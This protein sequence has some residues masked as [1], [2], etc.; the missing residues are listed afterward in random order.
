MKGFV[1]IVG[2]G[3]GDPELL[4]VKAMRALEASDVVLHDDLVSP[5]ILSLVPARALVVNVGKRCGKKA[6][7]QEQIEDLMVTH[8]NAGRVVVRLKGGDPAI[9]GRLAG[10]IDALRRAGTPFQIIPGVTSALAAAA[11]AQI[12]LTDRRCA[13]SVVFVPGHRQ[14]GMPEWRNFV[15][16]GATLVIYM[17]GSSYG[18]LARD[19]RGSGL[20]AD[21]PCLI[22]SRAGAAQQLTVRTT[23]RKLA[24]TAPLP[25]PALL[26]VGEVAAR[27][28]AS[29]PRTERPDLDAHAVVDVFADGAEAGSFGQ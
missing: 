22:V 11:G 3:P 27:P 2:A 20:R 18:A 29:A 4:T 21:T 14:S 28:E 16:S 1:Y 24:Q 19:L 10:E 5:E 9:F 6:I 26:V 7:S 8:A 25:S 12:P 13:S 17:P 23:L 15:A